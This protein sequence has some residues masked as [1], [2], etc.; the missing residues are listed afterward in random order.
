MMLNPDAQ[1][2]GQEEL[3]RVIGT[4]RM[5]TFDDQENLPFVNA[6]CLEAMRYVG[7]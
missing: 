2:R 7:Q 3:D 5:P 4:E 1:K 6:I